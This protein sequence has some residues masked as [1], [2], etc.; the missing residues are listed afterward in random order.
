VFEPPDPKAP[1]MPPLGRPHRAR[2]AVVFAL[3]AVALVVVAAFLLRTVR[4]AAGGQPPAEW[5]WTPDSLIR[6][7][8]PRA[9]YAVRDLTLEAPAP[10]AVARVVADEEYVLYVNGRR[11]GS[12]RYRGEETRFDLYRVG[13]LLRTGAN[14]VV[15]ELRSG[16]G[17]GGLLLSLDD[18]ASGRRLLVSDPS[19]RIVDHYH[20][21]VVE[22]WL[23]LQDARTARTWGP[24][25]A[26]RW[27]R[28]T[29]GPERP[30]FDAVAGGWLERRPLAPERSAGLNARAGR[31][32]D[33]QR[34]PVA[35]FDWGR[36]VYGYLVLEQDDTDGI[37]VAL[38]DFSDDA[39]HRGEID[40]ADAEVV[41]LPGAGTWRDAV[42]RRFRSVGVQGLP[43]LTGAWVEPVE[44]TWA[45]RLPEAPP[46]RPDGVF[47]VEP[48]PLRTPVEHEIRRQLQGVAGV[49]G[50]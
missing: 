3:A 9:F 45:A 44:E 40:E 29:D 27:G 46:A 12:N 4:V 23:G 17:A 22:G 15:V 39:P 28:V 35:R 2:R 32:S 36:E 11:V 6:Y 19:W 50:G 37:P 25:P 16:R 5:I 41:F 34:V 24:P 47:G 26:G 10:E 48:P 31:A 49:S 21:G 7:T 42:P 38:L 13:P 43:A 20:P 1:E 8:G 18:P 14:R 33:M 30:V